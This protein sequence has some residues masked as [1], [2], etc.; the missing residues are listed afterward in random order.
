M[1]T[2]LYVLGAVLGAAPGLPS[3]LLALAGAP[4]LET[5]PETRTDGRGAVSGNH[6]VVAPLPPEGASDTGDGGTGASP[7][8]GD[9]GH[10]TRAMEAAPLHP[11]E[12]IT[13]VAV[14]CDATRATCEYTYW[15]CPE[16][17]HPL[18]V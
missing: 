2:K 11:C 16:T 4:S 3:A 13:I 18:R 14:P 1:R 15:E 10:R 9:A 12:L 6:A 7:E 5:H 8:V 17:A